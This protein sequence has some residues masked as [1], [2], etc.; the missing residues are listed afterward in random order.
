MSVKGRPKS[1]V[2]KVIRMSKTSGGA[3]HGRILLDLI[4][5]RLENSGDKRPYI[6]PEQLARALRANPGVVLPPAIHN[7]LCDLLEDKVDRPRGRRKRSESA[8]RRLEMAAIPVIYERYLGWLMRRERSVGLAGWKAVRD[9]DWWQGPPSERAA[10]MT[11]ERLHLSIDWRR[12]LN[13]VSE[14]RKDRQS[15]LGTRSR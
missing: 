11:R 3:G 10:R 4:L 6:P 2:R 15:A 8:V 7:Y 1:P 14:A 13:T 12:I 5:D 9:Q